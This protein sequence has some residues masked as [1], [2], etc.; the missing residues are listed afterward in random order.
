MECLKAKFSKSLEYF[1]AKFSK[2][3]DYL[4]AEFSKSV[5]RSICAGLS[6]Q[7]DP[8][9]IAGLR[10]LPRAALVPLNPSILP[11][12][13]RVFSSFCTDGRLIKSAHIHGIQFFNGNVEA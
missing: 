1:E 2:S 7:E 4:K 11:R 13:V 3:L 8:G 9:G 5:R 12:L 10:P 6:L